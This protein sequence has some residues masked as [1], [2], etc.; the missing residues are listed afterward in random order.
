M[1]KFVAFL[2]ATALSAA[3]G[4]TAFAA[5]PDAYVVNFRADNNAESQKLDSEIYSAISMA[6]SNVE[7]VIIDTSNP[8]KWEKSAHEAFDRDIVPVFNQWVGLPGFAAIVD[9]KSKRVIGCV[10]GTFS[11]SEMAEQIRT[12]AAKASGAGYMSNA[13][14]RS[15]TTQCPAAH[16]VDPGR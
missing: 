15:K 3:F 14:T 11:S 13:S 1:N 9:A 16:N 7:H 8:A 4:T 6:G 2:S 10:N 12:M 5:S